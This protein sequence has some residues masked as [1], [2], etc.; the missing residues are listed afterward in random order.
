MY[1]FILNYSLYWVLGSVKWL[2]KSLCVMVQKAFMC[3]CA[4]FM[5]NMI[6]Q[7]AH[8]GLVSKGPQDLFCCSFFP[9]FKLPGTSLILI[10][11]LKFLPL[12]LFHLLS[13]ERRRQST[14]E[15][16]CKSCMNSICEV[17][18]ICQVLCQSFCT[19]Y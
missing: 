7:I 14:Q 19:C 9:I 1:C 3:V 12:P 17:L 8:T 11:A 6:Y 16:I 13:S 4:C 2:Y 15:Y 10:S 5:P 18:I